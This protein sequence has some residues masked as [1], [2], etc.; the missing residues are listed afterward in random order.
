MPPILRALLRG[1]ASEVWLL[2][3]LGEGVVKSGSIRGPADTSSPLPY[4]A[5]ERFGPESGMLTEMK[6]EVR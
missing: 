3:G 5:L 4:T 1:D 6:V 2:R